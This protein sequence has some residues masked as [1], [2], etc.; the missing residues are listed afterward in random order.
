MAVVLPGAGPSFWPR[1]LHRSP[2]GVAVLL[3]PLAPSL[4]CIS[5]LPMRRSADGG[6]WPPTS[7]VSEA[8]F[9]VPSPT[10]PRK[11]SSTLALLLWH[12]LFG[13]LEPS[14]PPRAGVVSMSAQQR[15]LQKKERGFLGL[16]LVALS[17]PGESPCPAK[18]VPL[19]TLAGS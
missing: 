4:L 1:P 5:W 12:Y 11:V 9:L 16:T 14:S 13:L 7:S 3:Q 2:Q 15:H 6:C 18:A 8:A 19:R 17:P 10:S